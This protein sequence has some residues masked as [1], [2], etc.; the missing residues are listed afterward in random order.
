MLVLIY[1]GNYDREGHGLYNRYIGNDVSTLHIDSPDA[2][3]PD[4]VVAAPVLV[5][6]YFEI[7]YR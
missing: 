1:H 4:C 5:L 3:L 7:C 2:V 6:N